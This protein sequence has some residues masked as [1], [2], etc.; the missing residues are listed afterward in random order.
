MKAN[1]WYVRTAILGS[2][3]GAG[4]TVHAADARG[5][6]AQRSAAPARPAIRSDVH[7]GARDNFVNPPSRAPGPDGAAR[8][9]FRRGG[10]RRDHDRGR[11]TTF[12]APLQTWAPYDWWYDGNSY[13]W[14]TLPDNVDG[15][16]ARADDT[17]TPTPPADTPGPAVEQGRALNS[18]EATPAYAQLV[19]EARKAQAAYDAASVRVLE[20]LK[21]DPNYQALLK[22]RDR[23]E[24]QVEAVQA[25]A[26]FPNP[27]KVTPAAQRKLEISARVTRMEQDAL[28]ADPQASQ[29]KAR[30]VELTEQVKAARKQ[31]EQSVTR[32]QQR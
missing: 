28:A 3:V 26:R 30:L 17:T 18:L 11:H 25:G 16:D 19:A 5:G 27:E 6:G 24:E 14:P 4:V 23:A 20:K 21:S 1:R 29:A 9:Q 13:P 8:Q 2:L 12:V 31:A 22:E 15:G 7:P 32:P 10:D